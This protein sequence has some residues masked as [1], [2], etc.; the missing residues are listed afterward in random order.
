MVRRAKREREREIKI[1]EEVVSNDRA[2][3]RA[4]EMRR[5]LDVKYKASNQGSSSSS[6][7]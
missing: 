5:K 2:G 6:R 3:N 4:K 1:E 7:A